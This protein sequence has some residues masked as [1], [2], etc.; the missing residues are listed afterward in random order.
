MTNK[1]NDNDIINKDTSQYIT[2]LIVS[3]YACFCLYKFSSS[4]KDI[5]WLNYLFIIV[6]IYLI[7]HLFFVE[8]IELKIHHII[9]IL[10]F[11]WYILCRDIGPFIKNELYILAF[12]EVSNIFLS[13]RN[14]IRHPSVIKFVSIPNFIQP[15]NDGL[16]A[17]TFFYT[18]IYLYFK[19][20][21]TNQEL[22]ENIIKYNRF[23]MC[24]KIIIMTIFLLFGLNLYWFGLICYGAFKI[25]GLN[26]IWTYNPDI[27]DPFILQI[28][29]IRN[30]L[31]KTGLHQ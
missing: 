4:D 30:T 20:I 16:F 6:V 29:A 19:H 8:K 31:F 28:E 5:K 26:R 23:F 1:L 10:I 13:I 24:D 15:I 14:I 7:I 2:T 11:G 9:F 25:I 18:R 12:A 3:L 21:I 17:I 27:K 22:I